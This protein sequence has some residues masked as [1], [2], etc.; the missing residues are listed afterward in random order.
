MPNENG[1]HISIEKTVDTKKIQEFVKQAN[2]TI[3]VGYLANEQHAQTLHKENRKAEPK[4]LEGNTPDNIKPLDNATLARM[5]HFGTANIPARPF[6][7]D[8]IRENLGKIKKTMQDETKKLKETG[9][10][11]WDKVGTMAVGAIN[12]FVR[13][14]YYKQR[15]PNSKK[16][17]KYK[18]SDTPLIDGANLVSSTAYNIN[19]GEFRHPMHK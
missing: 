6:L 13:S 11:N 5:L 3:L 7:T 19:G 9:K 15:K 17:I 16:T 1:L 2:V 14:D 4:D 12:E 18:G 10:A 8:A